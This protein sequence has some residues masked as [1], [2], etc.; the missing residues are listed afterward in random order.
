VVH[1]T[2]PKNGGD[3]GSTSQAAKPVI[4]ATTNEA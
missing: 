4:V 2:G 3:P 1:L